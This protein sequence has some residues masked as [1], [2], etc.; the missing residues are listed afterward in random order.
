M[1]SFRKETAS[2]HSVFVAKLKQASIYR[3]PDGW[4]IVTQWGA[5]FTRRELT[6]IG[7]Y[8]LSLDKPEIGVDEE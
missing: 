5:E 7:D 2:R 6:Q 8:M 1:I 3:D 4:K